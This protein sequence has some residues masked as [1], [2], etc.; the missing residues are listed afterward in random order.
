[1][2]ATMFS[3]LQVSFEQIGYRVKGMQAIVLEGE[4]CCTEGDTAAHLWDFISVTSVEETEENNIEKNVV[5]L[6]VT[7]CS[8]VYNDQRFRET[9]YLNFH[10]GRKSC[11]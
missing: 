8:L 4:V 11:S 6:Y 10:E 9:Y 5:F 3:S 1:M 7:P 2:N